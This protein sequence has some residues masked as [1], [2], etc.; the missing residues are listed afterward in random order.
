MEFSIIIPSYDEYKNLKNLIPKIMETFSKGFQNTE[1]EILIILKKNINIVPKKNICNN[2]F[3]IFREKDN[4]FGSAIRT[5]IK[6]AQGKFIIF[7]DADGSHSPHEIKLI[8]NNYSEYDLI[9]F[10]RY[11]FGGS[12]ENSFTLIFMSK[13]L[14]LIYSF[15]FRVPIKDMSNN[16]KMY[17]TNQ[18]KQLN[19]K[20]NNFDII[21][22]I[23][24][25]L[26]NNNK[27]LKYKEIQ[28]HFSNRK[29]GKTK[30][31]LIKFILTF[32]ITF[33]KLINLK[34]K[35]SE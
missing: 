17:R 20:S 14:N 5:G 33:V 9:C 2:V 28:S 29:H 31:N 24:L 10:S 13:M 6:Y 35:T 34:N 7:L 22:E 11:T 4:T 27:D 18:L 21:L 32:A 30:R 1:Y 25:K 16:F 3:R 12:T 19:L 8:S 15:F 26:F 23:L